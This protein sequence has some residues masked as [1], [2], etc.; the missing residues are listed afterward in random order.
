MIGKLLKI[1]LRTIILFCTLS[2]MSLIFSVIISKTSNSF[3]NFN[4][5]FPFK[6]YY[7]F[8]VRSECAT[9][10]QHNTIKTF[11]LYNLLICLLLVLLAYNFKLLNFKQQNK[12]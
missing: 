2:F 11:A 6:Y 9:E 8:Q 3:P 10:L 7:Q 4:I 5:G 1:S 12:K